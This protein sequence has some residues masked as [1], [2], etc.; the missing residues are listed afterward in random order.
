MSDSVL[1]E[2]NAQ[3]IINNQLLTVDLEAEKAKSSALIE[4]LST[5]QSEI[6]RLTALLAEQTAKI[7]GGS[8][9]QALVNENIL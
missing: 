7:E 9:D 2:V 3:T 8:P 5:A 1:G 4:Q 6:Q